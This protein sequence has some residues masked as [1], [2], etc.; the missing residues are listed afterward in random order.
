M[1]L[2]TR[3]YHAALHLMH[4]RRSVIKA[5]A[6]DL[7]FDDSVSGDRIYELLSEPAADVPQAV[8]D[9]FPFRNL[10][11]PEARRGLALHSASARPWLLS[12][13]SACLCPSPLC[14]PMNNHRSRNVRCPHAARWRRSFCSLF[15]E[16]ANLQASA[17]LLVEE[18]ALAR[19]A[20]LVKGDVDPGVFF[21]ADTLRNIAEAFGD[22]SDAWF[23]RRR[24]S[25]AYAS[26][27]LAPFPSQ[28]DL[29]D[30]VA[31]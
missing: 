28:P 21:D 22:E 23:A 9:A 11:P 12:L 19:A 18:K 20:G 25:E 1:R 8:T 2:Q 3:A 5:V 7:A 10:A 4:A 13:P 17:D 26:E 15:E 16:R 6:N 24:T 14:A 30:K 27:E 29:R 31:I